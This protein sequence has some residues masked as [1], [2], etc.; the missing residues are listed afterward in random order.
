MNDYKKT[1]EKM[2]KAESFV[3]LGKLLTSAREQGLQCE[4]PES[5]SN[6]TETIIFEITR[7]TLMK[8]ANFLVKSYEEQREIGSKIEDDLLNSG[9][10]SIKDHIP[11]YVQSLFVGLLMD[12]TESDTD[13]LKEGDFM[14]RLKNLYE[15]LPSS[16]IDVDKD[17]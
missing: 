10:T 5:C 8:F 2:F 13:I 6:C 1:V 15:Q 3:E 14:A 4:G 16:Y 11:Y 12:L 17:N 7:Q 9:N